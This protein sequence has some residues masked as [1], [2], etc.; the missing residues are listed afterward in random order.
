MRRYRTI[1]SSA[2]VVFLLLIGLMSWTGRARGNIHA[3]ADEDL[4]IRV[5]TDRGDGGI[6]G[7]G[8]RIWV[9]FEASHDCYVMLY[10]IDTDGFVHVLFPYDYEENNFVQGGVVYRLPDRGDRYALV[11]D[12]PKGIEYIQAVASCHPYPV[13]RW[14]RY[15]DPHH[16]WRTRFR[17]IEIRYIERIGGDPF[18]GMFQIVGRLLPVGYAH[19]VTTD[20]TFFY[21]RER[22]LYP[23]YLY[24]ED[25]GDPDI[26]WSIH[27]QPFD[28]Y[29][30]ICMIYEVRVYD[31]GLH[32]RHV[33]RYA[34]RFA[35]PDRKSVV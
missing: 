4:E 8:D 29:P 26:Y 7:S 19:L 11:V 5:W 28:P 15:W 10:N 12:G 27:W 23:R 2:G 35:R 9:Y 13:P 20:Y 18:E 24:Y 17:G 22:V 14:R 32:V 34:P 25:Y 16:R 3:V 31:D 30:R 6:Y 33:H 1:A 21:V